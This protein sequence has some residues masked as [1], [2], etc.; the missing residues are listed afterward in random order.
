[1]TD[2]IWDDP[3]IRPSGDFVSF[4]DKGD[5]VAGTITAI[6]RHTWPDGKVSPQIHLD[7]DDGAKT[8]TAGQV[9]LKAK[10]AELRPGVGDRI[11]IELVDIEKR[12]GGKTLKHFDVKVKA[13]EPP[14]VTA[15]DF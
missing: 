9:Q 14:T 4:T 8:V 7:T 15:D 3:E 11:R 2:S 13:G 10:L 1:M 5:H 6:G 12:E